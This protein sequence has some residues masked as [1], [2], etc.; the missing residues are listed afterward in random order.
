MLTS[1]QY[2]LIPNL[3][4]SDIDQRTENLNKFWKTLKDA[5]IIEHGNFLQLPE[6]TH[7]LGESLEP[8]I[9]FIRRCYRDLSDIA[10][11]R[12]TQRLRITGN[13]EVWY[14]VD[15]KEPK[16]VDAKTILVCSPKKDHYRNFDKLIGT[17]IR[18]VEELFFQWGG[19]PRF[20]LE[21]A[22]DESQ[23]KSPQNAIDTC[24]ER[25]LN[26][27]GESDHLSDMSHKLL[28]ICTNVTKWRKFQEA[29]VSTI[30]TIENSK[31]YQ[32]MNQN[33]ESIDIIVAP[34]KLFQ[35]TAAKKHPIKLNGLKKLVDKLGGKSGKDEISLYFVL[36]KNLYD[37]NPFIPPTI[38]LPKLNHA[39]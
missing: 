35:I 27:I 5:K 25:L 34:D 2:L 18:M 23:Q 32:P 19:I 31:Y 10:F 15:G 7:F 28:H 8:T 6:N 20:I 36:P 12:K 29:Y 30:D 3:H 21:K 22:Y 14:I 1:N 9:L 13:P 11:N 16:R 38:L 4:Y 33:F 39:G 17:T 26:Y 24:D 37:N